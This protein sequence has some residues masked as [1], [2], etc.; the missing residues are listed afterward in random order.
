MNRKHKTK[1]HMK[2][3]NVS[4]HEHI[5]EMFTAKKPLSQKKKS[6]EEMNM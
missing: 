1:N 4:Q 2:I 5:N 3:E 6:T